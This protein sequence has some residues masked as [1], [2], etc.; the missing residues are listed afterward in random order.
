MDEPQRNVV[1]AVSPHLDDAVLSAGATR[2][3]WLP[4]AAVLSFAPCFLASPSRP[5]LP[6]QRTSMPHVASVL[7]QWSSG[8]PKLIDLWPGSTALCQP[9]RS[10]PEF[11]GWRTSSPDHFCFEVEAAINKAPR[12]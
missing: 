3:Q 8:K 11:A 10:L 12:S 9:N 7:M 1:L 6:W 5:S 2:A 4:K